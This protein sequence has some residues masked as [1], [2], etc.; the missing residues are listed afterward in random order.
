MIVSKNTLT[1][2]EVK[3]IQLALT[4]M[5]ED[6]TDSSK[7]INFPFTPEARGL[8]A[9]ML[10]TAKSAL[11]KIAKASGHL[12]QLDPYQDGDEKEFLTKES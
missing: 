12:V 9:D 2:H 4:T 6:M 1:P 5:I 10:S 7:N 11:D 8:I 3:I